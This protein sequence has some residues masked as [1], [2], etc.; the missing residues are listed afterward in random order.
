[1]KRLWFITILEYIF[2]YQEIS[3]HFTN[4]SYS[5]FTIDYQN[6]TFLLDGKPF[7]YISGSIHYFRIHPYYWNDRLRRIRAAGLN[8][9]Q[10]YIPWNFHEVYNGRFVVLPVRGD[11]SITLYGCFTC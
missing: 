11:I 2:N 7:R 1:M 9:I 8:T 4:P 3:S 5:S 6:D 10:M